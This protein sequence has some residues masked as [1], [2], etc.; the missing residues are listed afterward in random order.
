MTDFGRAKIEEAKRNG[1]WDA[2]PPAAV[3][4]EQIACLSALLE[5]FE[6]ARANFQAMPLSVQKTYTRAYLDAKTESG[7]E[8][9][10][11]W[12]VDRLRRNLKPM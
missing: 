1:R 9:R 11:A 5:E 2:P 6:P 10:I 7:R 3:T 4:E 12:M 8:R